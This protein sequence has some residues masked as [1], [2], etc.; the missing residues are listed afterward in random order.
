MNLR[1]KEVY[2]LSFDE[3][4]VQ[5]SRNMYYS[6]FFIERIRDEKKFASKEELI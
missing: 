2:I 4:R 1:Q 3:E 5:F 6:Y